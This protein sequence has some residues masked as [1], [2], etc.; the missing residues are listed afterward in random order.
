MCEKQYE[1][2]ESLE[3]TLSEELCSFDMH[4]SYLSDDS[5]TGLKI[6]Y[7]CSKMEE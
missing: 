1:Q 5:G 3:L 2:T 4:D 6:E 7:K